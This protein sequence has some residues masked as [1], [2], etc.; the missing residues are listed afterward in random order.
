MSAIRTIGNIRALSLHGL[1]NEVLEFL[2]VNAQQV[3]GAG[4]LIAKLEASAETVADEQ[5]EQDEHAELIK[6]ARDQYKDEG[7]IE[8]DNDAFISLSDESKEGAYVQAWV[9]V[10]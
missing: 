8:I 4:D 2:K 6:V 1:N 3:E 7:S 10:E 5:Q 9:W